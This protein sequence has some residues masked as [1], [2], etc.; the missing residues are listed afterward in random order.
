MSWI[1]STMRVRG[2]DL[3][4]SEALGSSE[5]LGPLRRRTGPVW[6]LGIRIA[7]RLLRSRPEGAALQTQTQLRYFLFPPGSLGYKVCSAICRYI[8]NMNIE[9]NK[10]TWR[11]QL[12][13]FNGDRLIWGG[14]GSEA[15]AEL[16]RSRGHTFIKISIWDGIIFISATQTEKLFTKYSWTYT[17]AWQ[18]CLQGQPPAWKSRQNQCSCCFLNSIL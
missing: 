18:R 9:S 13:Q 4:E 17:E 8:Y 7:E 6:V 5:P 15:E 1:D 14:K 11:N 12:Q 16:F 10:L 3:L 2:L